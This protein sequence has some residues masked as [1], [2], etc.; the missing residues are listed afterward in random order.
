MYTIKHITSC[1]ALSLEIFMHHFTPEACHFPPHQSSSIKTQRK[2]SRVTCVPC[3]DFV[4]LVTKKNQVRVE[5]LIKSEKMAWLKALIKP[6]EQN[7]FVVCSLTLVN[8]DHEFMPRKIFHQDLLLIKFYDRSE[9]LRS[10]MSLVEFWEC[11]N[12]YPGGGSSGF[13]I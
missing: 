9:C 1:M 5:T 3:F 8:S 7:F 4:I 2:L 12:V 13:K 6:L 11:W 10:Y